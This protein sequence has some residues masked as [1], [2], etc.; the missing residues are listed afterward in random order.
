MASAG[1]DAA[2]G[3]S[4]L[5][6]SLQSMSAEQARLEGEQSYVI[7]APISGRVATLATGEGRAATSAR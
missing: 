7:K 1:I 4:R 5:N 3:V 2:Q 6:E